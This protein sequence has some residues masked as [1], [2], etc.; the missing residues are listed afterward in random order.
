[1]NTPRPIVAGGT[2]A[3]TATL[4]RHNLDMDAMI[5]DKSGDYTVVAWDRS[6][7]IRSTATM[8]LSLTAA[9][10]C[11]NGWFIDVLATTGTLTI[12]PDG[13]ETIDGASTLEVTVGQS[14]RIRCNGTA[15]YSQFKTTTIGTNVQAWDAQLDDIAA[16][17]VTD[18]NIIV[19]DGANWV[20]ESGATARASLGVNT[21]TDTAEGLVE[22]STSAENV[23]GTATDVFPDVA[24]VKEMVDTFSPPQLEMYY[25][26]TGNGAVATF[27]TSFAD[28]TINATGRNILGATL[29]SNQITGLVAGDYYA[30]WVVTAY[31]GSV[32][33]FPHVDTML[34]DVTGAAY[35]AASASGRLNDNTSVSITG[36]GFFTLGATSTISLRGVGEVSSLDNGVAANTG[37]VHNNSIIRLWKI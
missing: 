18:G 3:V 29:T 8:T 26:T 5:L 16:L 20:A 14:C 13:S 33:G 25:Q 31:A 4:A 9:A 11:G 35:L 22:K 12:D 27:S 36:A 15:F 21:A 30:Q 17:A 1:M 28:L 10:T 24:G 19:G 23:A 37:K 2:G 32:V 6:K 7:L 34:Y